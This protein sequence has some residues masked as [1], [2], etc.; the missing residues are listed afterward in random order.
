MA[1]T[2][3]LLGDVNVRIDG[4]EVDVG[5]ARQRC[6]LVALLVQANR[7]VPVDQLLD[8]VWADRP[9]QRAR[10]ALSGYVSRLR[11]VLAVT[12]SRP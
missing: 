4:Q 3:Q 9:P 6:V 2:F 11:Q 12:V 7:V 5:H 1:V 8:W 10:N